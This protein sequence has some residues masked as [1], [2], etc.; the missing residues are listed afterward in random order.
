MQQLISSD[1]FK[2]MGASAERGVEYHGPCPGC[3]GRDRFH[4]WP[5][6][7]KA[8]SFWCRQ[9]GKGGDAIEYYR[10]FEGLSYKEACARVGVDPKEFDKHAAPTNSKNGRRTGFVPTTT[11]QVQGDWATRSKKFADNCHLQL[12]ENSEQ[13][14]WLAARGIDRDQVVR[15]RLGWNQKDTWRQREAWGLDTIKKPDG[16]PKKLWLPAGLVIPLMENSE[17]TRLRIR[18]PEGKPKYYVIPG[19]SREPMVTRRQASGY[20]VVEAELDAICLDGVGGDLVGI[21][22]VGNSTAKPTAAI[23]PDLTAA[24]HVAVALDSDQPQFNEL[25]GRHES[26]GAAASTWWTSHLAHAKRLPVVGG[27]DP[28]EAFQAG[29][30]LRAWLLAGL[31]PRFR[32]EAERAAGKLADKNQ[33]AKKDQVSSDV[34]NCMHGEMKQLVELLAQLRGV[35]RVAENGY[36]I[37]ARYERRLSPDELEVKGVVNKLVFGGE[38][39]PRLLA[40]LPDGMWPPAKLAWFAGLNDG[41]GK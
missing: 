39:V 40:L 38:Y 26:P 16:H 5:E 10:L 15:Y 3:G 30:D 25:T 23:W 41:G 22:A 6:Q 9:C 8:G 7:G 2:K 24:V 36:T 21:V 20:V 14:A 28:G 33:V 29:E 4:V 13:L 19:S 17:V 27:K 31:P 34:P 11:D 18:R 1:G 12:L 37:G 35:I 32:L